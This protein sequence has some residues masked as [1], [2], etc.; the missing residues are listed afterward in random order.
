MIDKVKMIIVSKE[1][2]PSFQV[3][4]VSLFIYKFVVST[5]LNDTSFVEHIYFVTVFYRID[6]MG[7]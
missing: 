1:I 3:V 7:D 2:R 6:S 5:S 4:E